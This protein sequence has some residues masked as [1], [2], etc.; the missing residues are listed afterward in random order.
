MRRRWA[1]NFQLWKLL[2]IS[3]PPT[4]NILTKIGCA[5][6]FMAFRLIWL[7]L[8]KTNSSTLFMDWFAYWSKYH[9]L[10]IK[11]LLATGQT[12]TVING[13]F[14][15]SMKCKNS[16]SFFSFYFIV[17]IWQINPIRY[18]HEINTFQR[19]TGEKS[20]SPKR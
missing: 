17:R 20:F 6:V 5:I 7:L 13:M 4:N 15:F 10:C 3:H 18:C 2:K 8:M 16:I 19:W 11:C 9:I 14:L 1:Y 12:F